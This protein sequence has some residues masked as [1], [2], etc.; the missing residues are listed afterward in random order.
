MEN[1][2]SL[3]LPKSCKIK[4]LPLK[5][6]FDIIFSLCV[7]FFGAPIFFLIA[8][9]VAIPS[10]GRVVYIQKRIG[11]G[12]KPFNC[13]KFRTMHPNAD[14][15][16]KKLLEENPKL[17]DEWLKNH[18]LRHDPRITLIGRFLRKTSLDE[19]PQFINVIKGDLS[20]VGPRPVV[21]DELKRHLGPKAAKILS[22]RP[23]IT[24][25]WQVSG[26][27]DTNYANR[28]KLDEQYVDK[29]SFLLDLQLVLK[30]IPAMITSRGAY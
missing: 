16:L 14:K 8:L 1:I 25:L 29:R 24:G 13:Y 12:G 11:R 4:H 7:L 5:R 10:R 6:F 15:Q 28:V 17:K 9:L 18:K 22:I 3:V 21:E 2:E 20:I 23:G 19:L 30:T 27:N 26:R